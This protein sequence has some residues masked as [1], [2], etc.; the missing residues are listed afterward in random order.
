VSSSVRKVGESTIG[1]VNWKGF[2]AVTRFAKWMR[3][4]RQTGV[5]RRG[6]PA[7][8]GRHRH[9][10]GQ[11]VNPEVN[12]IIALY[13]E[14]VTASEASRGPSRRPFTSGPRRRPPG[15]ALPHGQ[16]PAQNVTSGFLSTPPSAPLPRS[17]A[18]HDRPFDHTEFGIDHRAGC[19]RR[20]QNPWDPTAR[21]AAPVAAR[22]PRSCSMAPLRRRRLDPHPGEL[23]WPGRPQGEPCA[24]FAGSPG[25]RH[26]VRPGDRTVVSKSRGTQRPCWTGSRARSRR[27][28]GCPDPEHPY[29]ET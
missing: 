9:Q 26:D 17:R 8:A 20:Q 7:R 29:V 1:S 10:P 4:G 25:R 6:Q 28:Y 21:P 27:P 16:P 14:A 3:P 24:C 5:E 18:G 22:L 11:E 19:L 15:P 2:R 12:A 23:L 13:E